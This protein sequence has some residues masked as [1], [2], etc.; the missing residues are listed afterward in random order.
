MS[1]RIVAEMIFSRSVSKACMQLRT[2]QCFQ[3]T[4]TGTNK[5]TWTQGNRSLACHTIDLQVCY[6]EH[7]ANA[8]NIQLDKASYE[9]RRSKK[10]EKRFITLAIAENYGTFKIQK[11]R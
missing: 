4:I 1:F 9:T 5:Y 6:R 10:K 3:F 7:A 8:L 11:S 2:R